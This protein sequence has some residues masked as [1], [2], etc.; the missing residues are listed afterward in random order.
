VSTVTE[1]NEAVKKLP[2]SEKGEFLN[3]LAEVNFD[4]AWDRL[5][6]HPQPRPRLDA[7]L[8]DSAAEP[9]E[10]LDPSRL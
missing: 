9:D 2:E 7:F 4:D 6:D 8:R 1:I 10:P 5:L 3:K